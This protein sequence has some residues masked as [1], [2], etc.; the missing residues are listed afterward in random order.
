MQLSTSPVGR[1]CRPTSTA[2]GPQIGCR[3]PDTEIKEKFNSVFVLVIIIVVIMVFVVFVV[4]MGFVV[5]IV[6]VVIIVFV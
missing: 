6:V 1:C 2:A 4:I 5:F 3:S